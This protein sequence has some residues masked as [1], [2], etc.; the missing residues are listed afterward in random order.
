MV[1]AALNGGRVGWAAPQ[2]WGREPGLPGP[3][4]EAS[5][6]F[7]DASNDDGLLLKNWTR[8]EFRELGIWEAGLPAEAMA[9]YE[10]LA[11]TSLKVPAYKTLEN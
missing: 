2:N 1:R 8:T 6:R 11:P 9:S 3:P 10:E 7:G 4:A 5:G